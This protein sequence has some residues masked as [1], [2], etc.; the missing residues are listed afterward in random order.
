MVRV[1]TQDFNGKRVTLADLGGQ[2]QGAAAKELQ[3]VTINGADTEE[4]VE[5]VDGQRERLLFA[6]LFV[7][8]LKATHTLKL[9]KGPTDGGSFRD[10]HLKHPGCDNF[11]HVR[12]NVRLDLREVVARGNGQAFETDQILQDPIVANHVVVRLG[13]LTVDILVDDL[14]AH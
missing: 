9:K 3:V 12:L 1:G 11:A 10:T 13:D 2:Q 7:T 14:L 6:L 8:D 5:E 4:P